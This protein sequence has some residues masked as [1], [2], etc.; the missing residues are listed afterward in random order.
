MN[1]EPLDGET[2]KKRGS[3]R[4]LVGLLIIVIWMLF[5]KAGPVGAVVCTV[6]VAIAGKWMYDRS[7]RTIQ[8][9]SGGFDSYAG[10]FGALSSKEIVKILVAEEL[11]NKRRSGMELVAKKTIGKR[12]IWTCCYILLN[13]LMVAGLYANDSAIAVCT[14]L[15]LFCAWR[16]LAADSL[17]MLAKAARKE[18]DTPI[19]QLVLRHTY[20]EGQTPK[21]RKLVVA[22]VVAMVL[23]LGLFVGMYHTERW[24]FE[25][26]EG[27]YRVDHHSTALFSGSEV[28][29]P[30]EHEGRPVV[31]I[32]EEAFAG[33]H[34][35]RRVSV[36]ASVRQI[37]Q[38]AFED[39]I[40]L[41]EVVLKEGLEQIGSGAFKDCAALERIAL[42]ETLDTLDGEAFMGC[43]SLRTVQ[44]P[45][46]VTQIRGNTFDGCESLESVTLHDQIVDI[47]AYAFQG[48]AALKSIELPSGITEI[49]A[50]TFQ[51]CTSLEA[52]HIPDGVT[53]I[54]AHAFYHCTSLQEVSVPDS[55]G[56]IRSSAFRE[57]ESLRQIVIPVGTV[58]DE[59]AFKDSPTVIRRRLNEQLQAQVQEE[60]DNSEPFVVSI[61][62]DIDDMI[63]R[64]QQGIGVAGGE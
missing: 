60:L 54:A 23:S 56:E 59:R 38:N 34:T 36:P 41:E 42:P 29:V 28:E 47:H 61:D 35:I 37:G 18:P 22:G 50:Y 26:V 33:D 10:G 20:D 30:A 49:H 45:W 21:R 4:W 46:G 6:C 55:V 53:R 25:P 19:D 15:F 27:G 62:W 24:S 11:E 58:V 48:C 1:V 51:D 13:F 43:K 12:V 32:G 44:I 52:I 39:C 3:P 17:S 7:R 14:V 57:C 5:C 63:A 40:R 64:S 2:R 16:F 8:E 31:A 9:L